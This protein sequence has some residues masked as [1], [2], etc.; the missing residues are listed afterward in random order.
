MTTYSYKCHC[1]YREDRSS[2][3]SP[4]IHCGATM[5]RDYKAESVGATFK[6]GGWARSR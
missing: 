5:K 3:L 6:G 2:D 1:G 4:P